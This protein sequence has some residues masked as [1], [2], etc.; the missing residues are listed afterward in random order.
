MTCAFVKNQTDD[1]DECMPDV[2]RCAWGVQKADDMCNV[3]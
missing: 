3:R 1:M 2:H